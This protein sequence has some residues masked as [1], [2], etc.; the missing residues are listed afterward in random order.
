MATKQITTVNPKS[1]PIQRASRTPAGGFDTRE[2]LT[3]KIQKYIFQQIDDFGDCGEAMERL[4]ERVAA[5]Y[6]GIA[7]SDLMSYESIRRIEKEAQ[8]VGLLPWPA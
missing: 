8:E 2:L 7:P 6:C 5:R 3:P 4:G 1:T